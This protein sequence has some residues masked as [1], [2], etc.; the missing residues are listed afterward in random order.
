[1]NEL[2]S[3]KT[4]LKMISK[5]IHIIIII[6][7]YIIQYAHPISS[8]EWYLHPLESKVI[9]EIPTLIDKAKSKSINTINERL[10]MLTRNMFPSKTKA[11]IPAQH[12]PNSRS[13]ISNF[14]TKQLKKF[15]KNQQAI[16]IPVE[17]NPSKLQVYTTKII[18][19]VSL[20]YI[21][22]VD[23][24]SSTVFNIGSKIYKWGI[25]HR[26]TLIV[27]SITL[28]VGILGYRVIKIIEN[29]Y[30]GL[31]E[32][33]LLLD[34]N[35]YHYQAY[36]KSLESFETILL[37]SFNESIAYSNKYS[38]LYN[39]LSLALETPCFPRTM[40]EYVTQSSRDISQLVIE[41]D[42]RIKN[43]KKLIKLKSKYFEATDIDLKISAFDQEALF[44]LING[45]IILQAR[46]SDANLRLIRLQMLSITN[47][48]E[49]LLKYW[50]K[51]LVSNSQSL[52]LPFPLSIVT[53]IAGLRQKIPFFRIPRRIFRFKSKSK[54][55]LQQNLDKSS[56]NQNT[57]SSNSSPML[58]SNGKRNMYV[59]SRRFPVGNQQAHE[60][61][62][63][64]NYS[65]DDISVTPNIEAE[66][67]TTADTD[68][69]KV[70]PV[71]ARQVF[72]TTVLNSLR[73]IVGLQP[74]VDSKFE[75][76][77][78]QS[79]SSMDFDSL[80][81][82]NDINATLPNK[83]PYQSASGNSIRHFKAKSITASSVAANVLSKNNNNLNPREKVLILNQ[84]IQ[85]LYNQIGKLQSHLSE[86]EKFNQI[87][88]DS[89]S[90]SSNPYYPKVSISQSTWESLQLWTEDALLLTNSSIDFI[91]NSKNF[92][93]YNLKDFTKL[94]NIYGS[95]TPRKSRYN[96]SKYNSSI[97]TKSALKLNDSRPYFYHSDND[98]SQVANNQLTNEQYQEFDLKKDSIVAVFILSNMLLFTSANK[99]QSFDDIYSKNFEILDTFVLDSDLGDIIERCVINPKIYSKG[100]DSSN[101]TNFNTPSISW[102]KISSNLFMDDQ[103]LKFNEILFDTNFTSVQDIDQ[104]DDFFPSKFLE[105]KNYFS[106]LWYRELNVTSTARSGLF[107][108]PSANSVS[109]LQVID[110]SN[111]VSDF[112]MGSI[113]GKVTV[114]S[115]HTN[116]K[117]EKNSYALKWEFESISTTVNAIS[118]QPVKDVI[119]SVNVAQLDSNHTKKD[120]RNDDLSIFKDTTTDSS[121]NVADD[122]YVNNQVG[123]NE[124]ESNMIE[125]GHVSNLN[126]SANIKLNSDANLNL[127]TSNVLTEDYSNSYVQRGGYTSYVDSLSL[128]AASKMSA[129]DDHIDEDFS[130]RLTKITISYIPYSLNDV[131]KKSSDIYKLM[132]SQLTSNTKKEIVNFI[133]LWKKAANQTI[134]YGPSHLNEA[135]ISSL[136][137]HEYELMECIGRILHHDESN[138]LSVNTDRPH[139]SLDENKLPYSQKSIDGV[140]STSMASRFVGTHSDDVSDTSK[141][142]EI[143]I[144]ANKSSSIYLIPSV[145]SISVSMIS[146]RLNILKYYCRLNAQIPR[147]KIFSNKRSSV[148]IFNENLERYDLKIRSPKHI[149]FIKRFL[150]INFWLKFC[151][152]SGLVYATAEVCQRPNEMVKVRDTIISNVK[153]FADRRV[154]I[155]FKSILND[156]IL[157]RRVSITDKA[158]LY[159]AQQSLTNMIYDFLLQHR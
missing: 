44:G 86:L 81:F 77:S 72:V 157:N 107:S 134:A 43:Q 76:G 42:N 30:Q 62:D 145:A 49:N 128:V 31:S 143:S 101:L 34:H 88:V 124:N 94:S 48:C 5:Y 85:S 140:D 65:D 136:S 50:E 93:V 108:L 4:N 155:P 23:K 79:A 111:I 142:S 99:N 150:T 56:N 15:N 61:S 16:E 71:R 69:T 26:P 137:R 153:D 52:R 126:E 106:N 82:N 63:I 51:R 89:Y 112:D 135:F 74:I 45:V 46:Q 105:K 6:C 13:P 146:N 98:S 87:N 123:V 25:T 18:D 129:I 90:R 80:S 154:V 114:L 130:P 58:Q 33:E 47:T 152:V 53:R 73:Y 92:F 97:A 10:N 21:Q 100:F 158:A 84:M 113:E 121:L 60:F 20:F 95:P 19:S 38:S 22:V 29:W 7:V 117:S 24:I 133:T 32:Y 70:Q 41:I 75:D 55:S 96:Q 141:I 17:T 139:H 35:D 138:Q 115:H 64:S 40:N 122:L 125:S 144:N 2:V 27:F 12:S 131:N 3:Q 8:H 11:N 109:M 151:F 127:L 66:F 119:E 57:N 36:G 91:S 147:S 149:I 104:Y 9:K 28:F 132:N 110:I 120:V 116:C 83:S 68:I 102:K 1:M 118:Q 59:Q 148:D 156:M 37:S 39:K 14:V 78:Y 54:K 67:A 159:D 103:T